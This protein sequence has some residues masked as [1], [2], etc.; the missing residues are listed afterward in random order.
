MIYSSKTAGMLKSLLQNIHLK[1]V[2]VNSKIKPINNETLAINLGTLFLKL[3]I[4]SYKIFTILTTQHL[5]VIFL[6]V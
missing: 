5:N 1:L 6:Q 3:K 4:V 2:R